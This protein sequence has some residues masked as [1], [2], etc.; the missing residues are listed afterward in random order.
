MKV[1]VAPHGWGG[2]RGTKSGTEE[3]MSTCQEA[4]TLEQSAESSIIQNVL[5]KGCARMC[6]GVCA[7]ARVYVCVCRQDQSEKNKRGKIKTYTKTVTFVVSGIKLTL[8]CRI[9]GKPPQPCLL[10]WGA[11]LCHSGDC[12]WAAGLPCLWSGWIGVKGRTMG[13]GPW[14]I[15]HWHL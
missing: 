5:N 1:N 15:V 11:N 2:G 4:N 9:V 13:G 10:F 7:R 3:I 14:C 12:G 8:N 6:F